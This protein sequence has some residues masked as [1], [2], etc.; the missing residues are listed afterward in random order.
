MV[1]NTG[2]SRDHGQSA[3]RRLASLKTALMPC[4]SSHRQSG[5]SS[6]SAVCSF[7]RM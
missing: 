5:T 7:H 1:G 6:T 2:P 4:A 3:L